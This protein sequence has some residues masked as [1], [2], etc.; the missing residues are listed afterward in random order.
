[1]KEITEFEKWYE[2]LQIQRT[3]KSLKKNNFD[4]RFVPKASYALA[5]IF[6]MI[7][8]DATVGVGG[9]QTLVQIG[10]FE[11]IKKHPVRFLNPS[12][13]G[14]SPEEVTEKR[15][16]ALLADFFLSSSNAITEDGEIYNID[17]IGNRI[18]AMMF[19]PKNVILVCGVNKIVKDI[20]EA[21]RRVHEIVAPINARRLSLKTP[22]AETG[23]CTDCSSPQRICNIYTVFAKKP[24][25]TNV[26]VIL[27]GEKLGF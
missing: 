4:A 5:E 12:I 11:E 9:S 22:C 6:K 19:G 8:K 15:R 16:E 7:P 2:D 27:V 3:L 17:S 20:N 10:F 26:T 25:R 1:M 24:M 14:M 21:K 23:Q 13:Q 18:A